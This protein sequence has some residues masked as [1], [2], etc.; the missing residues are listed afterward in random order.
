MDQ[1]E[2]YSKFELSG[3]LPV[4]GQR[5]LHIRAL[6]TERLKEVAKTTSNQQGA[7]DTRGIR[8]GPGSPTACTLGQDIAA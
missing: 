2:S 6:I 4:P 8:P 1:A 7:L 3:A 5:A